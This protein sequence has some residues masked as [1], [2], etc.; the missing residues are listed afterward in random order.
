M[1]KYYTRVCN[2][3]YGDV[4]ENLVK[5][6]KTLPVGGNSKISFDH[7]EILS[8]QNNKLIHIKEIKNLPIILKKKINN[9]LRNV[10]KKKKIFQI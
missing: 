8:R 1:E 3:Y 2:F 7:V 5:K 9:D 4:S 6:S 10:K